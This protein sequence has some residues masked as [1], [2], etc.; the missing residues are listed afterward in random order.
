MLTTVYNLNKFWYR[1]PLHLLFHVHINNWF[2]NLDESLSFWSCKESG[3]SN[4]QLT[5]KPWAYLCP[6]HF[7]C[8]SSRLQPFDTCRII[9]KNTCKATAFMYQVNI[10][11][12]SV[13]VNQMYHI[14]IY[15]H[16]LEQWKPRFCGF[17]HLTLV[18]FLPLSSSALQ[19]VT[20]IKCHTC[21][22]GDE[23]GKIRR[24]HHVQK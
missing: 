1:C 16:I 15:L 8:P 21:L 9:H 13:N 23:W 17:L 14:S 19:I 4:L 3:D 11:N 12:V 10:L 18:Y 5:N 6:L 2:V 20:Q 7:W 22:I 24:S